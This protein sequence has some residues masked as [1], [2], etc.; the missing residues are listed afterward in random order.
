MIE[1]IQDNFITYNS[2]IIYLKDGLLL[3]SLSQHFFIN[4][5]KLSGHFE[6]GVGLKSLLRTSSDTF[7]PVIF[8]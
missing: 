5:V 4:F 6:G 2:R 8:L 3:G 1:N 7:A